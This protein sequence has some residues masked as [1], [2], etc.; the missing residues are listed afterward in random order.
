MWDDV[1]IGNPLTPIFS[2]DD[3]ENSKSGISPMT[4][5]VGESFL[6]VC[7]TH[8]VSLQMTIPFDDDNNDAKLGD[9][10]MTDLD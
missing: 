8:R 6:H 10:S 9:L 5:H 4:R 1:A 7:R 3:I 2:N